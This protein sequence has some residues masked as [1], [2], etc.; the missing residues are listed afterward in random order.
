MTTLITGVDFVTVPTK[1]LEAAVDFYG[2]K[3][4]LRC[5][6]HMPE[7]SFA[8]FE[9]GQLTLSVVLAER[10][11]FGFHENVNPVALHVD[12]VEQARAELSERGVQFEGDTFDTSVCH[13]AFFKDPDGNSL[14]LHKRY[15]PRVTTG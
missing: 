13:M 7:R 11:P 6:V 1:D 5:S 10:F 3:L 15:A 12:D 9:A 2:T 14:M 8:E 4:G